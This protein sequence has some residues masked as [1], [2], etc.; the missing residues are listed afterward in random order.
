MF[1][2]SYKFL[3][4]VVLNLLLTL[5]ENMVAQIYSALVKSCI[6]LEKVEKTR[7]ITY[8]YVV[9][10]HALSHFFHFEPGIFLNFSKFVQK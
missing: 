10:A 1:L 5:L 8:K 4:L 9:L 3:V 2:N 7:L 6:L